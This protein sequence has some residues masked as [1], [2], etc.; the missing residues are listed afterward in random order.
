[1][2]FNDELTVAN[3][4][5]CC[6]TAWTRM[7][8]R[9]SLGQSMACALG[10]R[11]LSRRQRHPRTHVGDAVAGGMEAG[12]RLASDREYPVTRGPAGWRENSAV[13]MLD[14]G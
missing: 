12:R 4:T 11:R 2:A 10:P 1:M 7:A 9:L 8:R 6:T 13:L 14:V 5:L 3:A